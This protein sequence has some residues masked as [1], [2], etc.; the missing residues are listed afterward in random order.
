MVGAEQDRVA[1][2]GK[3]EDGLRQASDWYLW[4]P[5]VSERQW[6]TVRE[7]YSAGGEAWDYLPHDHARS[8]AYRWGEDGLAGFCDVEQRLCLGLALWNGRDPILKERAYGLTGAEANHGEDVKEYWWYLDALPSHAWNRWRYHYP[9]AAFPYEDLRRRTAGGV[10]GIPSTSCSTPASSTTTG[11]G[12]WRSITPRPTPRPVDVDPGDQCRPGGREAA[13]AAD[14]VV[15]QHLVLGRQR[16]Q[17]GAGRHRRPAIRPAIPSSA[18]WSCWPA[19]ARTGRARCRCFVRT[20]PTTDGCT[21]WRQSRLPQGRHQRPRGARRGHRQP[22]IAGDEVRRLVPADGGAGP[23]VELRLRLRP[24][25]TASPS[26]RDRAG[27]RLRQGGR[28]AGRGRRVLCR[29]DPQGGLAGRGH[30]DA[31]GLRRDVVEQA[32]VLLRRD[33]LAGR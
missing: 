32:A 19:R 9:Q 29:A 33:P 20:R 8:Q 11:T 12:S 3:L 25:S 16:A 5:Y 1:G 27:Q 22:W 31:P 15:S 28:S 24:G 4:G 6:G 13:C 21:G 14:G 23:T 18:S 30:G 26:R 10:S 17:A 7:D 2:F